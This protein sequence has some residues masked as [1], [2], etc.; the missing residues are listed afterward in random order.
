MAVPPRQ[1]SKHPHL[2]FYLPIK[3]E[4]L[5]EVHAVITAKADR[6]LAPLL[7]GQ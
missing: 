1:A 3:T 4:R 7:I 6:F 2:Q 5:I